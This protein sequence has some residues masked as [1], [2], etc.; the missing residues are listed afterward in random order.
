MG[1][2]RG[3]QARQVGQQ[4]LLGPGVRASLKLMRSE[5]V[6]DVKLG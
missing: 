5:Q 1:S 4:C 2:R 3:A 6:K